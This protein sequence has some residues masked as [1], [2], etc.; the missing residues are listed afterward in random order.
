MTTSQPGD[1]RT[2]SVAGHNLDLHIGDSE[3]EAWFEKLTAS[4]YEPGTTHFLL[5]DLRETSVFADIGAYIGYFT[6]LAGKVMAD[7]H[8][9]SFEMDRKNFEKL[10]RNVAANRLENVRTHRV[11]VTDKAGR[12]SYVKG[13][14]RYGSAH[15]LGRSRR[16]FWN[17]LINTTPLI[18]L[19]SFFGAGREPDVVKIDVQGAELGV[20]RGMRRL[21]SRSRL[22]VYVE[23]HPGAMRAGFNA[24]PEDLLGELRGHGFE[25]FVIPDF[26]GQVPTLEPL[27]ESTKVAEET[28]V[29]ARK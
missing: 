26:R 29:Y 12:G 21:L 2:I 1:I 22:K 7:G 4:D 25:L 18:T 28:M 23:V 15:Q 17:N 14:D 5:Q 6:L 3:S 9:E 13:P 11:A 16:R 20:I 8:V 19:D 27:Q 10:Q 24:D